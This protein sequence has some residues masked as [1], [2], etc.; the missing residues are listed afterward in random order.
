MLI[1][2]GFCDAQDAIEELKR[3]YHHVLRELMQIF[4]QFLILI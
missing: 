2:H 3:L 1:D 4:Q